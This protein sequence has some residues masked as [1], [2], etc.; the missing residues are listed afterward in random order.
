[1]LWY[2]SP[3]E[4]RPNDD[5]RARRRG[6]PEEAGSGEGRN[7]KQMLRVSR[8]VASSGESATL[9][10]T[11]RVQELRRQ[12]VDVVGFGA[13]EPDFD[14]P[15]P[16]KRAGIEAIERNF[17]KYTHSSGMPELREGIAKR[18]LEDYG[19]RY[20]ASQIIVSC[21]AK[22]A[23]YNALLTLCDDGDEVLIPAP[24]WVSYPDMVRLVGGSPV[25]VPT[26]PERGFKATVED[27]ERATTPR[28]KV[29]ILNSP[30]NPTG[31]VYSAAELA[32][33][34]AFLARRGI[35]VISDDIYASLV[36]GGTPFACIASVAKETLPLAVLV[37]GASKAYAMTGWRI[38][39][40]A[41][42]KEII[43]AMGRVQ[44]QITSNPSSVAQKA[45][46]A[47]VTGD[48]ESMIRPM[49]AEFD[50]RRRL[51]TARLNAIPGF[52]CHEPDGAFYCF[53]E[54]GA[55]F[56]KIGP[57]GK[58]IGTSDRFAEAALEGA[59]VA[60]LSGTPFGAPN[61]VRLS[62]ATSLGE[63]ERGLDR[64]ETFVRTLR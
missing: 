14:T 8:R 5:S 10:L 36:Y 19:L 32:P 31:A 43:A 44:G 30:G 25:V 21:G 63:I 9:A 1:M 45:A 23:I 7:P 29:L 56:G 51:M 3:P 38:G 28:T 22:Q 16:V 46:L 17:T 48:Q 13:G 18:F 15:E 47:A 55:L 34:G 61:H 62:Y 39:W 60:L 50:R 53:P 41:G 57:D 35:A 24:Y 11:A 20:D 2:K 54:I 27:L 4:S 42:P 59:R 52:R 40:A 58:P 64:L 37:N 12:G 26:S 33:I 49:R 6:A